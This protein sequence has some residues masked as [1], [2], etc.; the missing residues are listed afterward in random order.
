MLT[1]SPVKTIHIHHNGKGLFATSFSLTNKVKIYDSLNIKPTT[2]PLEQI[3]AIYSC[4]STIPE[5]LQVAL[6]ACQ[7][8]NVDCGLFAIAYATDLAIGNNPAEIMYDQ[9]EMRN[10][11]LN[12]LQSNK[13]KPFPR[14]NRTSSEEQLID[15]TNNIEDTNK[16]IS[17]KKFSKLDTCHKPKQSSFKSKN[18]YDVLLNCNNEQPDIDFKKSVQ[19]VQ[20]EHQQEAPILSDILT[21]MIKNKNNHKTCNKET[22]SNFNHRLRDKTIVNLSK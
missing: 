12:C 2:E 13:I 11:L 9:C 5:I 21:T 18:S 16:W 20:A 6:P 19:S 8:G 4:D 15:I 1:F 14:F 3:T 7:N 10:H 22:F 17:P